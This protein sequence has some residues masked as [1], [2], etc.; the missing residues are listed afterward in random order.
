MRTR[1]SLNNENEEN[2]L[3]RTTK[4][5]LSRKRALYPLYYTRSC[6]AKFH[7]LP[8]EIIVKIFLFLPHDELYQNVRQVCSRWRNLCLN[9][10]VWIHVN[11]PEKIPTSV[12]SH[13]VKIARKLRSISMDSRFDAGEILPQVMFPI[14]CKHF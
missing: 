5:R 9:P 6:K 14:F 13:W 4:R 2:P 11:V 7:N 12:L 10:N 8:D 3:R 1:S